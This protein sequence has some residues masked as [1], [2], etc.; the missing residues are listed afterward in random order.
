MKKGFLVAIILIALFLTSCSDSGPENPALNFNIGDVVIVKDS[1]LPVCKHKKV[2]DKLSDMAHNN[3]DAAF[4]KLLTAAIITG[5]CT[6]FKKNTIA[7]VEDLSIYGYVKIRKK[8][9]VAEY[10]A[11]GSALSK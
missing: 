2:L 9:D 8:G 5:E 3:D 7:Y 11:F 1:A 4:K 6:M 10:W